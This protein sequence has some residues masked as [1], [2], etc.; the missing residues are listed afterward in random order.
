MLEAE[1]QVNLFIK[2]LDGGFAFLLTGVRI[3][4]KFFHRSKVARPIYQFNFI[5]GAHSTFAKHLHNPEFSVKNGTYW[6]RHTPVFS[7][8][9]L[10]GTDMHDYSSNIIFTAVGIRK[11]NQC[12]TYLLGATLHTEQLEQVIAVYHLPQAI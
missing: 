6:E 7:K 11:I 5:N 10:V 3:N 2:A 1:E 4:Q 9:P 12:I 8:F